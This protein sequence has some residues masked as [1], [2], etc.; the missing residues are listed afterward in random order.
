MKSELTFKVATI[1]NNKDGTP[2]VETFTI[3]DLIAKTFKPRF[4]ARPYDAYHHHKAEEKRLSA[5]SRDAR[6]AG[7]M[8]LAKALKA[9]ARH[10]KELQTEVKDGPALMPYIYRNDITFK[11][12]QEGYKT[13]DNKR[14]THFSLLMLDIESKITIDEIH[15]VLAP[16]EYLL[17]TTISHKPDDPRYRV[18]LFLAKPLLPVQ[19]VAIIARIDALLP[20]RNDVSKKTQAIDPACLD[21][22][23]RLM[24]L[25]TWLHKHPES[26]TFK[27][28]EGKL[29]EEDDFALTPEQEAA[30]Q[31]RT[32]QTETA[33][34]TRVTTQRAKI[35]AES[36]DGTVVLQRGDQVFLNPNGY[37]ETDEGWVRVGDIRSKIGN[38]SC[39][40][41]GDSN[42]SEFADYS[43]RSDNVY[44]RCKHCGTV[45]MDRQKE[46]DSKLVMPW[47]RKE[48]PQ[49]VKIA[50]PETA[51]GV[52]AL[53]FADANI[54][55]LNDRYLPEELH[56][57]IP[58]TG[59]TLIKSPKGTGKTTALAPLVIEAR[60]H[61]GRNA[62]FGWKA[63]DEGG[64]QMTYK[65]GELPQSILLIGHRVNLLR[66]LSERLDLDFYLDLGNE[67]EPEVSPYMAVCMDSLTRFSTSDNQLAPHTIII[68][69]SEQVFKHLLS[70]T[71]RDRR[72]EVFNRLVWMM[73]NATRVILLDA[74]M[75]SDMSLEMALM[76]RGRRKVADEP[77]LGII[78][79]YVF[80]GRKTLVYESWHHLLYEAVAAADR[81]EKVFIS[82]NWRESGADVFA[83]I[84]RE[85]GKNVLLVTSQTSAE[86]PEVIEFMTNTSEESKK[87]DV[88]I[89]TPT[90]QTG[91][92]IDND[93]FDHVFG[94]FWNSV[95]T[96]QDI[97]QAMSR[98]RRVNL[99]K[100]W[101]EQ[102]NH[103]SV[104]Q[105]EQELF[106]EVIKRE[107]LGARKIVLGEE[108]A[109]LTQGERLWAEIYARVS[110]LEQEWSRHKL[111]QFVD[112]RSENGY[113]FEAVLTDKQAMQLGKELYTT[114]RDRPGPKRVDDLWAAAD[115]TPEDYDRLCMKTRRSSEEQLTVERY[116][117]KQKL[118]E[119]WSYDLLHRAVQQDLLRVTWKLEQLVKWDDESRVN[120]DR[121]SRKRNSVTFTDASHLT[122]QA[123]LY[124]VLCEAIG[125]PL[126]E[127]IALARKAAEGQEVNLEI[128][129][130]Q[131]KKLAEAYSE[132]RVEFSRY[133]KC[134]IKEPEN[135]KN[136]KKIWDA[137]LG[138]FLPLMRRKLGSKDKRETRYFINWENVDMVVKFFDPQ[139]QETRMTET[140][141]SD[142]AP[143]AAVDTDEPQDEVGVMIA[144]YQRRTKK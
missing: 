25:P 83:G 114:A 41:H 106:D 21:E 91:V 33:R 50:T 110:F 111:Q 81:G 119:S 69:E 126:P 56:L 71:L 141:P 5:E 42:G 20:A 118:G 115:L 31:E 48:L 19:A 101:V 135:E 44:L 68:D 53:Q 17:W 18:V 40:V 129:K 29:V 54:L 125:I 128:T 55:E 4:V 143:T 9:E 133:L 79:K 6:N 92:S 23:G 27:H 140:Q 67:E 51:R 134:R 73:R 138:V 97:D 32:R 47:K 98:V 102:V 87:Y 112:L 137:T 36:T 108:E 75:T 57:V 99:H 65:E 14:I 24:Y 76:L 12:N 39:P 43:V 88:V 61:P 3:G 80:Q 74:D 72:T 64:M 46:D 131:L 58:E 132:R 11:V 136:F 82:T 15:A 130:D 144:E 109:G 105:T 45:W 35:L 66:E 52:D 2:K 107:K 8:E 117:Y 10:Y 13:R 60:K 7:D 93:H 49:T 121:A 16:Y 95:G 90:V 59:L 100:V 120:Y 86:D 113:E 124:D 70:D 96:F 63:T 104:P 30:V 62:S 85:M 116:R 94:I 38:V 34:L 77:Y 127:L 1:R 37:L 122:L 26:Y 142:K 89:C 103:K 78:N 123:G 139:E 28:N 22:A 84:F